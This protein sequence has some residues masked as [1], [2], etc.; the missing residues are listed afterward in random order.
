MVERVPK[1]SD[2]E[3]VIRFPGCSGYPVGMAQSDEPGRPKASNGKPEEFQRF[4]E[5]AR[6]LTRV[7]KA[8]LD[9]KRN[10]A[11][12]PSRSARRK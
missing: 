7:S 12:T 2:D 6:K 9:A 8:E 1:V 3:T 4:E 5:L 10:G 11:K